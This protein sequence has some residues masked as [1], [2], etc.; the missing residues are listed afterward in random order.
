MMQNLNIY[1]INLFES[2]LYGD[3]QEHVEEL[4]YDPMELTLV[5]GGLPE[6]L[7]FS[8]KLFQFI[9]NFDLHISAQTS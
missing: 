3:R 5:A 4:F 8:F 7:D 9:E 6:S 2:V 1:N